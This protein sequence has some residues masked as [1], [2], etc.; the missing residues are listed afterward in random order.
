M[1]TQLAN[2]DPQLENSFGIIA[3]AVQGIQPSYSGGIRVI[4]I[5][6]ITLLGMHK[7]DVTRTDAT[8]YPT[9]SPTRRLQ[10]YRFLTGM[11][12]TACIMAVHHSHALVAWTDPNISILDPPNAQTVTR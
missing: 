2:P 3:H 7:V 11:G 9:E 10:L 5:R 4:R 12:E 8:R 6:A 1:P